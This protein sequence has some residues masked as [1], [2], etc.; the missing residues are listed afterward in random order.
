MKRVL[1]LGA[2]VPFVKGGAERLNQGLVRQLNRSGGVRAELVQLP[3]KWYP[4]I[5]ILR[6]LAAWRLLDL[7]E[8]NGLPIDMVIGTKFPS[9]LAKHSNMVVWLV[10]QHRPFY[11]LEGTEWDAHRAPTRRSERLRDTVRRLDTAALA[12]ARRVFTISGTVAG[13]L[14]RYCGVEAE[15]LYPPSDLASR[16]YREGYD[17]HIVYFG[18]IDRL[19]RVHLLIESVA[20]V[21]E[22]R[23]LIIGTG[24]REDIES[25]EELI[26][27]QGVD[28]RCRLLGWMDDDDMLQILA[29][30]RA[31]FY[32][33][34]D[35]DYGY[36]AVE[37]FHACK[38]VITTTDAG[39]VCDLV[40]RTGAGLVTEP[41]AEA[42]AAS[43]AAVEAAAPARLEEM[44][45]PGHRLA[46][47]ITW[48]AVIERLVHQS[49][50]AT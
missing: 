9:Y 15:A 38:P 45:M 49:L 11:D 29:R 50:A 21:T 7:T 1:V 43:I 26:R 3:F 19:K 41:D 14:R 4:E 40:R 30:C 37:A 24:S 33:P 35:E 20:R 10:H 48:Q 44:A 8:S 25:L 12:A 27:A 36:S 34:Y 17:N 6:D 16:I 18:R 46:R 13:R 22:A 47:G 5:Q 42:L 2:Q 31:V 32:A 39:E 23:A 28:D